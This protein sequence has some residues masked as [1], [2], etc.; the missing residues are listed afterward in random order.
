M[1]LMLQ[2]S[3]LEMFCIIDGNKER[4]K[5]VKMKNTTAT[6]KFQPQ[7]EYSGSEF[8]INIFSMKPSH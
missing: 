7:R 1:Y 2:I 6:C 3:L 8:Y 5:R 4:K